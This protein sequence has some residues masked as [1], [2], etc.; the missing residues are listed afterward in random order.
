VRGAKSFRFVGRRITRNEPARTK[1]HS[2]F[3][4]LFVHIT[5]RAVMRI[6]PQKALSWQ[7]LYKYLPRQMLT[8]FFDVF[9]SRVER[10]LK[11]L[12]DIPRRVSCRRRNQIGWR[13][14][15]KDGKLEK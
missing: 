6:F 2:V 4:P 1:A 11:F 9:L 13:R 12:M 8:G 14:R 7:D 5:H 3:S 15:T 10:R